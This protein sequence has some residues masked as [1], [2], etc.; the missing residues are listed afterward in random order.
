[1]P[2][3]QISRSV[4]TVTVSKS[5]MLKNSFHDVLIEEKNKDPDAPAAL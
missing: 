2:P 3:P 5:A 4:S 1:M